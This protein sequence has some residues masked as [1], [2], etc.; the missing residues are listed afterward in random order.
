VNLS[1]PLGSQHKKESGYRE[2][3][4]FRASGEK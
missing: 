4:D 2:S 1:H 3:G